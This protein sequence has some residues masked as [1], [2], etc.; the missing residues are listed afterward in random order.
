MCGLDTE[1][2]QSYFLWTLT[3]DKL[4]HTMFP[5]GKYTKTE[6]RN[7]A[8]KFML[9]TADKKDSQG[10]C[11]IG[12]IEIKEFLKNYVQT[13]QGNVLDKDGNIIGSHD[14]AIFYTLGQ[15]HDFTVTKKLPTQNALYVVEKDMLANTITV[16][17]RS[18]INSHRKERV[19]VEIKSV[20][21][22]H[23]HSPSFTKRYK[24]RLRY[25]QSLQFCKITKCEGETASIAFDKG[26]EVVPPGQSLVLYD[27]SICLGGG[28]IV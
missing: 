7:L 4:R 10:L 1:K 17:P 22:I 19:E 26:Q 6:V 11:F 9:P 5:I 16:L 21:W 12:E 18:E 13:K 24:A 3:Q 14:G 23:G 8:K 15:R 28:V 25:R 20:N 27:K 2:D